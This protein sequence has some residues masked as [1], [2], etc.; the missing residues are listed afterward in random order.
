MG[1]VVPSQV[2]SQTFPASYMR[3]LGYPQNGPRDLH[4]RAK[5]IGVGLTGSASQLG[6]Q[7]PLACAQNPP[8]EP[9]C[10]PLPVDLVGVPKHPSVV[11]A[12]VQAGESLP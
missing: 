7:G 3:A 11:L 8:A 10:M 6:G 4:I 12:L 5:S 9:G 1:G 2:T